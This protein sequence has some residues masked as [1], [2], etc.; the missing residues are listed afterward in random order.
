MFKTFVNAWKLPDLRKKIVYTIIIV[1][2]YRI[3]CV[4]PLPFI[5]PTAIAAWFN[6]SANSSIL[7][8]FNILSGNTFSR[9]TLFALSVS[10]YITAQ[11]V[12]QLLT[13]AIPSLEKLS[14]DEDGRMK[15]T[16][17]TRYLTVALGIL[18]SYGYYATLNSSKIDAITK[19]GFF[20]CIV[21]MMCQTAGAVLVMWVSE[22]LTE[23]GIG[24]G[25]SILLFVN[26]VSAIPTMGSAFVAQFSLYKGYTI[27][28]FAAMIIVAV[29]IV[30]FIVFMSQSERR[31]PVQY[32]KRVVGRKM[33]GGQS[34]FL[35]MKLN[36]SGVMPIIFA[37]TIA[38][39]PAT[40]AMFC[41]QPEAG[42]FWYKFLNNF[43]SMQ[44]VP[45]AVV[46]FLL[47]IAFSY[48]YLAISFNPVE[49]ANNLKKNGGFVLGMRPGKPTSDYIA[50]V[51]RKIT[52]IGGFFLGIIAIIPIVIGWIT[53]PFGISFGALSFG[54]TSLLIVVSVALETTR[55]LDSQIT[56]R[57]YKGFLE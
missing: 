45:Y 50:R 38:T 23:K 4:L 54:G 43:F 41:P 55:D 47:I 46:L 14:K 39:L 25:I 34:T 56:M 3:G 26:I 1:L 18:T 35:P 28:I 20:A 44:S 37:S 48:F 33:Y 12:I 8:Y 24:Q 7:S 51:L 49:V 13:I 57:H 27:L 30:A 31:L 42:S 36:M 6:S 11:I 17:I 2:I 22:R 19:P 10:P 32:A 16:Q 15:I 52:L 29:L 40:I 5:D 53:N 21:I 9:A